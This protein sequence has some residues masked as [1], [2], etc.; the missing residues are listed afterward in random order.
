MANVS[1]SISSIQSPGPSGS[2][3]WAGGITEIQFSGT[4][5]GAVFRIDFSTNGGV[6]WAEAF[7][8]NPEVLFESVEDVQRID[9]PSGLI[10][11]YGLKIG[12]N[13]DAKMTATL[14]ENSTNG[15]EA[16]VFGGYPSLIA[17]ENQNPVLE[18]DIKLQ[19]IEDLF[20]NKGS[21]ALTNGKLIIGDGVN[22]PK[23][24][25]R[26]DISAPSK[27]MISTVD[28][29]ISGVDETTLVEVLQLRQNFVIGAQLEGNAVLHQA[30]IFE[31]FLLIGQTGGIDLQLELEVEATAGLLPLNEQS[32]SGSGSAV[33][34]CLKNVYVI[35]NSDIS[36]VIGDNSGDHLN[37][38]ALLWSE[39]NAGTT[40]ENPRLYFKV[41]IG[42]ETNEDAIINPGAATVKMWMRQKSAD[43][44]R[45]G[46]I[47]AAKI[48]S[49]SFSQLTITG[50]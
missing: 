32:F 27:V 35:G 15:L 47:S 42:F 43:G 12:S 24:L 31:G 40:Y 36:P 46:L 28:Y 19:E 41:L 49:G 8:R 38:S 48:L 33:C 39:A 50:A 9:I 16:D 23:N 26:L 17:D 30:A 13:T 18:T 29:D 44:A 2:I 20:L 34:K 25:P 6:S 37:A 1:K 10:R 7:P 4:F 14:I 3:A 11:V 22:V 21:L 5:D 45:N